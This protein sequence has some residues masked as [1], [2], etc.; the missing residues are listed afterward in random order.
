MR[1]TKQNEIIL[2]TLILLVLFIVAEEVLIA[3]TLVVARVGRAVGTIVQV[4]R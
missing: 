2:T 4:V 3:Q 1:Y